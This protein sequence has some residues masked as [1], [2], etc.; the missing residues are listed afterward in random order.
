MMQPEWCSR[1]PLF[2]ASNGK[3]SLGERRS[4]TLLLVSR[5][6]RARSGRQGLD[7]T[8]SVCLGQ[9]EPAG[10]AEAVVESRLP[11]QKLG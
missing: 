3:R 10:A 5:I 11:A 1:Q 7:M 2:Q 6:Q 9:S 8:C 4:Q